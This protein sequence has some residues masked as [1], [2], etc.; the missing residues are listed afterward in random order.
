MKINVSPEEFAS[1]IM[2][3]LLDK[4][5]NNE[6]LEPD[7]ENFNEVM[8]KFDRMKSHLAQFYLN[9]DINNRIYYKRLRSVL[10]R[11]GKDERFTIN[12]FKKEEET[13]ESESIN[14]LHEEE[15]KV[16]KGELKT[17][18]KDVIKRIRKRK[19]RKATYMSDSELEKI[20]SKAI[21]DNKGEN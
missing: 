16:D 15:N 9:T 4:I 2:V 19:F 20:I 8:E 14:N 12:I 3:Y 11:E 6:E 1:I 10:E 18:I 17:L 5:N 7:N 13:N 21:K